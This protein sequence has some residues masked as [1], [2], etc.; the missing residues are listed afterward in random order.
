MAKAEFLKRWRND[1]KFRFQMRQKGI[2]VIQ[3]NVI[4]FNPDGTVK[5]VAGAYVG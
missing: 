4:F 2:W 5:S 1:W 3:D